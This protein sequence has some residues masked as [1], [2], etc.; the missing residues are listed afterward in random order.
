ME[1]GYKYEFSYML[2]DKSVK[3]QI[4][5]NPTKCVESATLKFKR[6]NLGQVWFKINHLGYEGKR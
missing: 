1:V 3:V 4:I 6:M 2:A 5:T